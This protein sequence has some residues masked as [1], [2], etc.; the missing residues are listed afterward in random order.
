[1]KLA[2]VGS[3]CI[4]Y[5]KNLNGGTPYPG[6]GPVNMAVYTKRLGGEAAY[7][8]LVG[9][10]AF[11]KVM[12]DAV[13]SKGVD[14]SRLHIREGKTAVTE[15]E[16]IDGD[17]KFGI[18]E[19][20]VLADYVLTEEDMDFIAGYDVVVCDLWG[21]VEGQ[22]KDLQ[23]R[24][25]PTAF[26]GATRPEDPAGKIALPYSDYF[27]FSAAEGKDTPKLREQLKRYWNAG[28]KLV[29]ATMG[30]TGSICY[31]GKRY[32][33]CGIV[34]CEKIVD[35]MGAGDSYI[36]GFLYGITEGLSIEEA[37]KKG[38]AN[39]AETIGYFGAW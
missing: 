38:A 2:A 20:G 10:D 4:D 29:V 15:V 25:V 6:G 27:F 26:D 3:N 18:Y 17:R 5:Y 37:M 31:D 36:A 35:T 30:A 32:Y 11:G 14:T 22:F 13:T 8:G 33:V 39:A 28:P 34:P 9:N 23:A 19:E 1:M 16:L 24:G 21:K 7:I 12:I